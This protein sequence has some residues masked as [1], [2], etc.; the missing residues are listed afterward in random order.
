MKRYKVLV[1]DDNV[2]LLA[3]V[4]VRLEAEGYDVITTQDGYQALSFAAHEKPDLLVLDVKMPA[5]SGLSVHERMNA[6]DEVRDIPVIYITGVG[7]DDIDAEAHRL[8]AFAVLHKP[9]ETG[10]F[11]EIVRDALAYVA[12]PAAMS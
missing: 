7:R 3:A 6:L 2:K 11:L 9:F 10:R 12:G 4:K 5:G 8:G 1:A